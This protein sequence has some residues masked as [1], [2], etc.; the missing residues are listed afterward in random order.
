MSGSARLFSRLQSTPNPSPSGE[1]CSIFAYDCPRGDCTL[2]D[3]LPFTGRGVTVDRCRVD[4]PLRRSRSAV[5]NL[6]LGQ[7]A[8]YR[9]LMLKTAGA[10]RQA[11]A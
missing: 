1:G 8:S 9:L 11:I 6:H 7:R 5:G 4:A 2:A 3:M 10:Y